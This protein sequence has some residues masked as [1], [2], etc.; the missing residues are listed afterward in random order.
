MKVGS[1]EFQQ[2]VGRYRD[3]ARRA[4]VGIAGNGRDHAVPVPVH[5]F[6]TAPRGRIALRGEELDDE[7]LAAIAVAEVPRGI[8]T[9][10]REGLTRSVAACGFTHPG[11]DASRDMESPIRMLFRAF[12]RRQGPQAARRRGRYPKGGGGGWRNKHDASD[13]VRRRNDRAKHDGLSS[14]GGRP[15]ERTPFAPGAP[16]PAEA[17]EGMKVGRATL[18]FTIRKDTPT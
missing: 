6:E 1:T 17:R 10:R 12:H 13:C 2:N 7:T 9:S 4:P 15:D 16:S 14:G 3:A 5:L 18:V 11:S 8:R